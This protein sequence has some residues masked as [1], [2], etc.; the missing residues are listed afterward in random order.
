MVK[1]PPALTHP[2]GV[3]L[4]V[5]AQLPATEALVSVVEVLVPVPVTV[6]VPVTAPVRVRVLPPDF[7]VYVRVPLTVSF[8]FTR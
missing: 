5:I 3:P 7:T 1:G 2:A 8:E 6:A 4:P